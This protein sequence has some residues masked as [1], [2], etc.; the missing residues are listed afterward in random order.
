[1]PD[2]RYPGRPLQRIVA[3]RSLHAR[4]AEG[5]DAITWFDLHTRTA[6]PI[7][8]ANWSRV[9]DGL[10]IHI[11]VTFAPRPLLVTPPR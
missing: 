11:R 3:D 4:V 2:D 8:T 6:L 1:M 7:P 5:S 10:V 9:Q